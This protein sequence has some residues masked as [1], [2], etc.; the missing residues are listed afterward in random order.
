MIFHTPEA[1]AE[2]DRM[3]RESNLWTAQERESMRKDR[4]RGN[5]E[6]E[7]ACAVQELEK[8]DRTVAALIEALEGVSKQYLQTRDHLGGD[9]TGQDCPVCNARAL[10]DSLK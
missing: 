3:K 9:H 10:L 4:W 1:A 5:S 7:L 8:A 6:V 2:Y